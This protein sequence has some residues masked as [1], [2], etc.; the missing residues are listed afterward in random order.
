M[1][2]SPN[3]TTGQFRLDVRNGQTG[4]VRIEVLNVLGSTLLTVEDAKT[5]D[6]YARTLELSHLPGGTYV[7]RFSAGQTV[8]RKK[9]VKL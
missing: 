9:I 5:A 3:P 8:I 1:L 6:A 4:K 2:L 7:V